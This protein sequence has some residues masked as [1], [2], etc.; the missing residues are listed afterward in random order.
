MKYI[1][2]TAF[3][4]K[5]IYIKSLKEKKTRSCFT[6]DMF[7]FAYRKIS[8]LSISTIFEPGPFS[9][10][11]YALYTWYGV[12][13]VNNDFHFVVF[14]LQ[15]RARQFSISGN[16]K[17]RD[18][19]VAKSESEKTKPIIFIF[20][21]KSVKSPP[22]LQGNQMDNWPKRATKTT[23]TNQ[24]NCSLRTR[25][26]EK[27]F[28]ASAH[29]IHRNSVKWVILALILSITS[30]WVAFERCQMEWWVIVITPFSSVRQ[31][32]E[33]YPN[34]PEVNIGGAFLTDR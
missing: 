10:L 4:N 1:G 18:E 25:C 3:H 23:A 22:L 32:S 17:A 8:T 15:G 12:R 7:K 26:A 14:F 27:Q 16:S 28:F 9:S 13:I 19:S 29:S 30:I 5:K 24:L 21:A 6:A 2:M 31:K 34:W 33:R 11:H 20:C